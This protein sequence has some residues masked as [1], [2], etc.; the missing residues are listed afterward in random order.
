MT[1]DHFKLNTV[2]RT[3]DILS[4][5]WPHIGLRLSYGETIGLSIP[6]FPVL[7]LVSTRQCEQAAYPAFAGPK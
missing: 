3:N 5:Y 2:M 1:L 6:P 4:F 7:R